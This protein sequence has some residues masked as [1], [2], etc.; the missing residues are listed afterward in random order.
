ML[1]DHQKR[2]SSRTCS[3]CFLID[4]CCKSLQKLRQQF[5][6]FLCKGLFN[7]LAHL[8]HISPD[9]IGIAVILVRQHQMVLTPVG[10]GILALEIALLDT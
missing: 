7:L 6:F 4:Y 10:R 8:I 2:K 1:T 3:C 9:R 5:L